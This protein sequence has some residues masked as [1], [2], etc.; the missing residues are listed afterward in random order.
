MFIGR[1]CA[2]NSEKARRVDIIT[3]KNRNT[4]PHGV[5][6]FANYFIYN[7]YIPSGFLSG[8]FKKILK[9]PKG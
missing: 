7:N 1:N 5:L 2:G 4:T 8:H 6:S 3:A 9:S